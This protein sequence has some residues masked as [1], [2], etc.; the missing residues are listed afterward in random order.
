MAPAPGPS[1]A[2]GPSG[3][4]MGLL[5]KIKAD[6]AS[7]ALPAKMASAFA[8]MSTRPNQA[9]MANSQAKLARIAQAEAQKKAEEQM[10]L[11][12]NK[13]AEYL[14]KIGQNEI[15]D[16]I[17]A[18]PQMGAQLFAQFAKSQYAKP[19]ETF[20]QVKGSELGITGPD[21]EKMFNVN[22]A[23]GKVG[24]IGGGGTNVTVENRGN[25]P[26]GYQLVTDPATG[27]Q[28]MAP[29]PG[30]PAAVEQQETQEK[31]ERLQGQR[32][33]AATTVVQDLQRMQNLIGDFAIQEE[34]GDSTLGRVIGAGSRAALA[35]V[36]GTPEFQA[37][38]FKES[39]LS[40]IGIDQLMQM[41]FNSPTGGALGQVP[42]QQQQRLEQ[43]L[44]ALDLTQR[45]EALQDNINRIQNIYMDTIH[46]TRQERLRLL[47]EGKV[48][49]EQFDEIEGLYKPLTFDA[50]GNPVEKEPPPPPPADAGG[51]MT[52]PSGARYRV[53]PGG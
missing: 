29:I 1:P 12:A 24:S 15:A 26:A 28:S 37:N 18:N 39:A 42:F 47:Q 20:K 16:A 8:G 4:P 6:W 3:A 33:T 36:P 43:L 9:V 31:S 30:S 22:E 40:N 10:A 41:K 5:D 46:G 53:K 11:K 50:Q 27:T 2:A 35:S 14:R 48:T 38:K 19:E 21:A 52:H 25:I 49:Q 44:G 23:T 17:I 32:A 13:T 7:G 51:W 45:P 34:S